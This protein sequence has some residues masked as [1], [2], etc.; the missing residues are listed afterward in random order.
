MKRHLTL[1]AVVVGMASPWAVLAQVPANPLDYSRSTSY[2]YNADGTIK[3]ETV[4][5]DIAPACNVRS[6]SYDAFGNVVAS[7]LSKC[8]GATGRAAI[9]TRT[10][11]FAYPVVAEQSIDVAGVATPVNVPAGLFASSSTN[12][13]AQTGTSQFDPRFGSIVKATDPNGL[14][15]LREVDDFGRVTKETSPVG[16]SKVYFYCVLASSGL[17]T[18]S[19]TPGCP[20]PDPVEPPPDAVMLVHSEPRG[21]T[22]LKS[23]VFVRTYTDRLGRVLRTVTQGYDGPSQPSGLIGA[24]VAKDVVYAA[25]GAKSM[26][27]QPYFLSTGG[28][29]TDESIVGVTSYQYDELGRVVNTTSADSQGKAG[30]VTFGAT[31]A[32]SYGRYG[33]L[34][35]ASTSANYRGLTVQFINDKGQFRRE[36]ADAL[37]HLVR[38]TDVYGA[39]V[40]YQMD[41]Y[42]NVIKTIDAL[43]NVISTSWNIKGQKTQMTDPDKGTWNYDYDAVGKEVWSQSPNQLAAGTSTTASYDLLG[44]IVSRSEPEFSSTWT[45][46]KY[47]D[48]SA[49][50]KGI[51]RLC[52]ATT[53]AGARRRV[54]FDAYGRESSARFDIASDGKAFAMMKTYSTVTGDPVYT[55]YPTGARV[56]NLYTANGY[57]KG[58]A[59]YTATNLTPMP[60]LDGASEPATTIPSATYLWQANVV[61]ATGAPEQELYL[62]DV[63]RQTSRF[64]L[65]GRVSAIAVGAGSSTAVVDH[66]YVWDSLGNLTSRVDNNGDGAGAVSETFGYDGINR[67]TRYTVAGPEIPDFSRD[68]RLQF[69]ALGMLLQKSDVGS[70]TYPASGPGSVRPHAPTAVSGAVTASFDYD[71]QGNMTAADAGKYRS[72]DFT[73]FDLPSGNGGVAGPAGSPVY[74]WQYDD[75]HGRIKETRTVAGT[76]TRTTWMLHPDAAGELFFESEKNEPDTPSA[77]NPAITT[78]RHYVVAGKRVL[79][80]FTTTGDV[81]ALTATQTA[82]TTVSSIASNKVEL[83]HNDH[84]GNL[85]ATTNHGGTI[86][87]RY[88]YDPFGKRRDAN[89]SYDAAS[90]LEVDYD[91]A[92]ASGTDRGFTQHEHLDDVGIVHMNGR[93]YDPTLGLFV[94]A[95]TIVTTPANLQNYNRYGYVLNNPLNAT[96]PTGYDVSE[97]FRTAWNNTIDFFGFA[98]NGGNGIGVS[99]NSNPSYGSAANSGKVA[100]GM[101]TN[102]GASYDL[103]AGA[104]RSDISLFAESYINASIDYY[105]GLH[106]EL[107]GGRNDAAWLNGVYTRM[108]LEFFFSVPEDFTRAGGADYGVMA[109]GVIPAGKVFNWVKLRPWIFKEERAADAFGHAYENLYKPARATRENPMEF[110]LYTQ[111]EL[112]DVTLYHGT[113]NWGYL[114]EHN[115]FYKDH[116]KVSSYENGQIF[117]TPDMSTAMHFAAE[118]TRSGSGIA[119][120]KFKRLELQMLQDEKKIITRPDMY[121]PNGPEV[122]FPR[123]WENFLNDHAVKRKLG[124]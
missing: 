4:E 64:P 1:V 29:R 71:A 28:T 120:F 75:M 70:Y 67:L 103:V 95:D 49:C 69:N 73:S 87:G 16:T 44:R 108:G 30:T 24:L 41:A 39:Q 112:D 88:A 17:S 94:Q 116:I 57:L 36:E 55:Y 86:T 101:P 14:D 20:T 102:G 3:T 35:A 90:A 84:L 97:F 123:G 45:Y 79:G 21:T 107:P 77:E 66:T 98:N 46:D 48:G 91:P 47:A 52:E 43:Q 118:G 111:H 61:D 76:G 104:G 26:E 7:T 58:V 12:A 78:N 85:V 121:Y 81:P 110:Y 89:G 68:V 56:A 10:Q 19:N 15:T 42:G 6:F 99:F 105:K 60:G 82:P 72:L 32:V 50:A 5:P 100:N 34:Q 65:D 117:L 113:T 63:T 31:G 59:L 2:D 33:S 114:A 122:V 53:S 23:G 80:Y 40:A 83:W 115:G 13:L 22:N 96:D 119:M 74:G 92:K 8:A 38:A 124:P 109:M 93:L 37:G 54:Y 27:T 106:N 9:A 62:G 25:S 11:K 51:G 18:A